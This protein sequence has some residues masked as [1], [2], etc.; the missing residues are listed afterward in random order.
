METGES[1]I[2][3]SPKYPALVYLEATLLFFGA[4]FLFH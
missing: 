4:N 1:R 2:V 3:P